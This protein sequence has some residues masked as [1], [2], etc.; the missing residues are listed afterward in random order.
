MLGGDGGGSGSDMGDLDEEAVGGDVPFV[1]P[2]VGHVV[3]GLLFAGEDG[4]DEAGSS[5]GDG[6]CG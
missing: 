1:N 4:R 2:F 3:R 5:G 6:L